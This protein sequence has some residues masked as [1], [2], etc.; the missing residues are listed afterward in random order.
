MKLLIIGLPPRATIEDLRTLLFRYSHAACR[1]I[2]LIGE[3]DDHPCRAGGLRGRDLDDGEQ[4]TPTPAWN[5]LA[6][7][8]PRRAHPFVLGCEQRGRG[9]M[10]GADYSARYALTM[11]T[12]SQRYPTSTVG[13]FLGTSCT[14]RESVHGARW[15][16]MRNG[17]AEPSILGSIAATASSRSWRHSP[18]GALGMRPLNSRSGPSVSGTLAL[19]TLC[20]LR[21]TYLG[22]LVDQPARE[23]SSCAS[24]T[25][26]IFA[27]SNTLAENRTAS[28]SAG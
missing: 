20:G 2:Q 11:F 28:N 21:S 16:P 3:S 27:P 24:S 23:V 15:I 4:H 5:V 9:E 22:A 17:C 25:N 6:S 10:S 13:K 12:N 8:P 19:R 7:P 14:Y 26:G 18:R 1:D